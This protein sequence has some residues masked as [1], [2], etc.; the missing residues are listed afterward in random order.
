VQIEPWSAD[1]TSNAIQGSLAGWHTFVTQVMNGT[2]RYFVDGKS[3]AEH[4]GK[5]YPDAPMSI[6]FNLW[7][8]DGGLSKAEGVREYQ[9]DID[10]VFHEAGVLLAP[11]EVDAKINKLRN[12]AVKF[13]DTVLPG[14]QA[15]PC[16]L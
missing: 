8:I 10:W 4:S 7:F 9:E 13:Q 3:I 11:D 12:N 6:N 14:S 1:N 5:Y 16:D 15:S 2:V